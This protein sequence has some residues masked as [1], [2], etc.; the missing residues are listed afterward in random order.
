MQSSLGIA[1][2]N[3]R[4][5]DRAAPPLARAVAESPENRGLARMLAMAWLNTEAYAKAADLLRDDPERDADPSLQFAYGLALVKSDRGDEAVPL[6]RRVVESKPPPAGAQYLLGK[7][8]LGQG[9]AAEAL[10]HLEAAVRASPDDASAHYQ[11]GRAYQKLGQSAR[12]E[13]EFERSRQ[14]KE[15]R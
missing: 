1:Y 13:Q 8:L 12:A 15:K 4:Q 5:F 9:A 3:A 11:L 7:V 6:L 14:L 10:V 2:F